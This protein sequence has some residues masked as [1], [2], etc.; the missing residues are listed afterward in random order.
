MADLNDVQK[1][2]QDS[3]NVELAQV[4]E[5]FNNNFTTNV[6]RIGVLELDVKTS[7]EKRDALKTMIRNATGLE[8]ITEEGLKTILEK[9]G[10]EVDEVLKKEN[11][12]L[13]GQLA[14]SANAV[15]SV[16]QKYTGEIN[17]M[18]LERAASMMGAEEQTKGSHAF[19][20]VLAELSKNA[21]FDEEEITY[22]NTDGTTIFAKEGSPAGIKDMFEA[23]KA[24]SKF[25]Y[26]F[27]DQFKKGGG[28]HPNGPT[29]NSSGVS[30]RRSTMSAEEKVTYI[31]KN[32]ITAYSSLPF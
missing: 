21:K 12:N 13:R 2:L 18:K 10:G 17:G 14:E 19:Q 6:E 5:G 1:H 26:L 23:L 4:I 28:K 20:T 31:A 29:K 15:D 9:G 16:T 32:S 24:D 8:T 27:K 25:E 11:D 3:G 7:A 22:K 30:L